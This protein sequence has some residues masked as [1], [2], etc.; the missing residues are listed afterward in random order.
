MLTGTSGYSYKEWVGP[1]YP[2]KLPASAMLRYYAERL[3]TVE[4]NNTF[5]R[6]P[7]EATLER[8]A[9]EV[10]E[11]FSFTL[12]A[13]R[14]ITHDRRLKDV[15]SEVLEFARRAAVLGDKLGMLLFQLPPTL[16]KDLPR[17][18]A[19]LGALPPGPRA[20]LEF[21]HVSWHDEEVYETL[22]AHGASLCVAETDEDASTP[23]V[24]TSD[25]AYLRLRRTQYED[26][27]LR[28]WAGRIA[29]QPLARAYVYFKHEDEALA[30]KFALR[31]EELW[32]E[33]SGPP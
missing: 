17:L 14:R 22:R 20:A 32:R 13:P 33:A 28:A 23:F 24:R 27:D 31:L 12:K 30:P 15:G 5:Y 29:A 4:V 1:F 21:R 26:G 19:F 2:Q 10:P 3:P 18:R 7:E 16:R 8:W 25:H 9:G 11:G 6:M